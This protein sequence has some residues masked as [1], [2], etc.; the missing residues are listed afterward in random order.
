MPPQ[1]NREPA[2]SSV[3]AKEEQPREGVMYNVRV[4][5]AGTT[6]VEENRI[7][8][9]TFWRIVPLLVAGYCVAFLDRV[10]IGFTQLQ[11]GAAVGI[12]PAQFGFAA[13]IFFLTYALLELPSNL[14]FQRI[15]ARKTFLRIMFLWGLVVIAT[16]WVTSA[17]QFYILRL[18][19]GAFEAGFFP[20]VVLY[21]T[22]WFPSAQRG[23]VTAVIFLALPLGGTIVGPLTGAIM[24]GLDGALGLQGW[25]WVFIV[26][27][28]PACLL[29]VMCYLYLH[30]SPRTAPWLT[31]A[32]KAHLLEQL[33]QDEERAPAKSGHPVGSTL[34][35]P[36]AY[37]LSFLYFVPTCGFYL[38]N[39]WLPTLIRE[40]GVS[41]IM[42]IGLL[43]TIPMLCGIAGLLAMNFSSDLF[44]E[45][46]WHL[47]ACFLLAAAGLLMAAWLKGSTYTL[48]VSLCVAN[49][50]LTALGPLFWTLP[51][52][53]FGR[54][55]AAT[56]IALVSTIGITAGFVSPSVLG[57]IKAQTGDL[58]LGIYGIAVLLLVCVPLLIWA[59]PERAM[60]VGGKPA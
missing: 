40:S 50:G 49:I 5:D 42:N 27:G 46:R 32:E 25:Q 45:R 10:N 8:Q 57:Y 22:W 13:G 31:D 59:V 47:V 2:G 54:A 16:A 36:V 29:G 35:D 60:R 28:I 7:F 3:T 14:L 34:K 4:A 53:Y 1:N 38:F 9:K 17:T 39:F 23:R 37:L 43:S 26:Q 19:L 58:T 41:Q 33:R 21:L 51:P 20:G 11:M 12:N 55:A 6:A 56:G 44:K 18:L 52:T 24:S 15:G 48:L 30:E